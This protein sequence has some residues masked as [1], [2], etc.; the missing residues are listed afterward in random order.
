MDLGYGGGA[1]LVDG[2]SGPCIDYFYFCKTR[3][4]SLTT[5]T[6]ILQWIAQQILQTKISNH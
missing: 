1:N 6:I 4:E 3:P 5:T 2:P